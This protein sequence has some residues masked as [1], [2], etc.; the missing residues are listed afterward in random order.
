MSGFLE[1]ARRYEEEAED[2]SAAYLHSLDTYFL[3]KAHDWKLSY[4]NCKYKE[5]E[6]LDKFRDRDLKA[7]KSLL[8]LLQWLGISPDINLLLIAMLHHL[9]KYLKKIL[10]QNPVNNHKPPFLHL[11]VLF[12]QQDCR[13]TDSW[14]HELI[15]EREKKILETLFESGCTITHEHRGITAWALSFFSPWRSHFI[16]YNLSEEFLKRGADPNIIIYCLDKHIKTDF[17]CGRLSWNQ[18]IET[19]T[20]WYFPMHVFFRD[21]KRQVNDEIYAATWK[22]ANP[23][24]KLA[25]LF[26]EKGANPWLKDSRGETIID[27]ARKYDPRAA[28]FILNLY[29]TRTQGNSLLSTPTLP[30]ALPKRKSSTSLATES[31]AK[32]LAVDRSDES[33]SN[34]E[35]SEGQGQC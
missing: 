29:A 15:F 16:S 31:S 9:Y 35:T 5:Y 27:T 26:I 10:Q 1:V 33:N 11:A 8:A 12:L 24:V 32:R 19:A 22:S 34:Q 13:N 2:T 17:F 18:A 3:S 20:N 25:Q 30:L 23:S 7:L 28:E 14:D 21:L 6:R 4:L